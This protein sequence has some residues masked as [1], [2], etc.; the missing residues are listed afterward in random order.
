VQALMHSWQ[1]PLGTFHPY[2]LAAV[3]LIGFGIYTFSLALLA[4][5]WQLP[6]AILSGFCVGLAVAEATIRQMVCFHRHA[7]PSVYLPE[8]KD[9]SLPPPG[10]T[11]VKCSRCGRAGVLP[12]ELATGL[13]GEGLC[14]S[15]SPP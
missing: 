4:G 8:W 3:M 11:L 5:W 10:L 9:D 2:G 1:R 14:G 7:M 12:T 6:P 15:C 13:T